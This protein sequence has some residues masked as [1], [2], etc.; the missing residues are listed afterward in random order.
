LPIAD[1]RE[2]IGLHDGNLHC[3][4]SP[5]Y[6][7]RLIRPQIIPTSA[8]LSPTNKGRQSTREEILSEIGQT[9]F[10]SGFKKGKVFSDG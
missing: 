1:V 7:L 3:S 2:E 8:L 10:S 6:R 9:R 5:P 4:L